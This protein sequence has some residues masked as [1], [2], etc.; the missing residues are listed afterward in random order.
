RPISF[1]GWAGCQ[2]YL[3][4][5]PTL[6]ALEQGVEGE[7][8]WPDVVE[9]GEPAAQ[10][11]IPATV[12]PRSLQNR[13]VPWRLH[14]ADRRLVPARGSADRTEVRIRQVEALPAR[15]HLFGH[16]VKG[17]R[18]QDRVAP[19]AGQEE[20]GDPLR[21]L[22]PDPRELGQLLNQPADRSRYIIH[23]FRPSTRHLT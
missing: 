11:V 23:F 1:H 4:H 5:P 13:Q 21:R 2:N 19:V 22:R 16:A 14:D 9:R 15:P 6:H 17:I 12:I 7:L 10:D 3:F 18:Q 8:F 20:V